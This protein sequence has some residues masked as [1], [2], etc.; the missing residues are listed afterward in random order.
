MT[1]AAFFDWA[2]AQDVR[3][4]FNGMEPVAMTGGTRNHNRICQNIWFALRSRLGG[5][6]FEVLGP[7]AGLATIGQTVRY[8]DALVTD[9]P[10]PGDDH[11]VPGAVVVFEVLSP[12]SERTDR[13]EKLIEYR[14]VASIRRY[15]IVDSA[16]VAANIFFR[17]AGQFE[18]TATAVTD[19][20]PVPLP[21][22]NIDMALHE[23]YDGVAFPGA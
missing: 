17:D 15:I 13:I 18:W 21:E 1:R 20:D 10:G 14:A 4:E 3:H 5:S 23:F 12:G 8:P 16:F 7:D 6:G 2:Q 19:A 22:I 11:L 9:T